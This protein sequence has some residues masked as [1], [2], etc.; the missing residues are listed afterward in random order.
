MTIKPMLVVLATY[1]RLDD[2]E[3]DYEAVMG[4]HKRGD[5][6]HVSAAIVQKGS[7]GDLAI[8]RHDTTANH[9]VWAGAIVGGLL[10]VIIPPLALAPLGW[11]LAVDGLAAVVVAATAA[12]PIV[13]V[14]AAV[15]AGTGGVIGHYWR[16]IPKHDLREMTDVL[17][18]GEVGLVVVAVDKVHADIDAALSRAHTK[19]AKHLQ[20]MDVEK[21]YEEA[22]LEA[23]A[24]RLVKSV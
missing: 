4:L 3:L 10:G 8:H 7:T 12:T 19:I 23:E 13:V 15:L 22:V 17:E 9:L 18:A 6:G 5:L 1:D 24:P 21:A 14:D 2:A 11:G 16:Q 20:D